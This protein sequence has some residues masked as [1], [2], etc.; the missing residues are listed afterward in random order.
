MSRCCY[1][2]MIILGVVFC[3]SLII[4]IPLHL[5]GYQHHNQINER[6]VWTDCRIVEREAQLYRCS[7][8]CDCFDLMVGEVT[9]TI[10]STCYYDCWRPIWTVNFYTPNETKYTRYLKYSSWLKSHDRALW[11]VNQYQKDKRYKCLYDPE[12]NYNVSWNYHDVKKFFISMW[13]FYAVAILVGV[14][15]L[16]IVGV[17]VSCF[18]VEKLKY[19]I[20]DYKSRC[21]RRSTNDVELGKGTTPT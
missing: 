3:C 19:Q 8:D 14:V 16:I 20:N 2:S 17:A 4:A 18:I 21:Q 11:I 1:V 15:V 9:T 5:A 6:S 12:D 10:C 7:E 13:F